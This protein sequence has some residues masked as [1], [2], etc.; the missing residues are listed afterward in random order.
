M[1]ARLKIEPYDARLGCLAF[2]HDGVWLVVDP[3][4]KLVACTGAD[5]YEARTV[6]MY[7]NLTE[8]WG[9]RHV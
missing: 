4:G 2:Q 9:R 3:T 7:H 8:T 1:T 6:A 5:E